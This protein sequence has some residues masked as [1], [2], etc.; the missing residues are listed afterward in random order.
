MFALIQESRDGNKNFWF[1]NHREKTE[2]ESW[3]KKQRGLIQEVKGMIHE[4]RLWFKNH[5]IWFKNHDE[6]SRWFKNQ[7]PRPL[8]DSRIKRADSRIRGLDSWINAWFKNQEPYFRLLI[9]DSDGSWN[10]P[11]PD[12]ARIPGDPLW[13]RW[14]RSYQCRLRR[15][16]VICTMWYG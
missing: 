7:R 2:I 1:L 6:K 15:F 5:P 14:Y 8:V 10:L 3:I 12:F 13:K 11:G 4:S 9:L 16:W